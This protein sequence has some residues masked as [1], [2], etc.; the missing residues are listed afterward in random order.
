MFLCQPLLQSVF[1]EYLNVF[2]PNT[3]PKCIFG[4]YIFEKCIFR[5]YIFHKC[6]FGKYVF[7]KWI[8]SQ[9]WNGEW[10][11]GISKCFYTSHLSKGNGWTLYSCQFFCHANFQLISF[12]WILIVCAPDIHTSHC[13]AFEGILSGIKRIYWNKSQTIKWLGFWVRFMKCCN[14]EW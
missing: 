9:R 4:K 11:T 1:L 8:I 3:F 7:Q 12:F 13:P 2:I 10:R 14:N 6:I 5:K